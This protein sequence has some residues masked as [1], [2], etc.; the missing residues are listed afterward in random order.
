M[1]V[2]IY[3]LIIILNVNGLNVPIKRHTV[4]EWK[5]KNKINIHVTFSLQI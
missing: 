5:Q 4:P 1:A 2:S 3:L